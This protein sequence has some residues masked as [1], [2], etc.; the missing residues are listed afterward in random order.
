M[1]IIIPEEINEMLEK[2]KPF[3]HYV[4]GEGVVLVPDAPDDIVKL[5]EKTLEWFRKNDLG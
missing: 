3:L 4:E 2:Q 1:R 5:R